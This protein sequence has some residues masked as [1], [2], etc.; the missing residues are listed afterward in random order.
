M[1]KHIPSLHMIANLHRNRAGLEMRI[2]RKIPIAHIDHEVI[3]SESFHGHTLRRTR[4]LFRHPVGRLYHCPT[5][6]G[7]HR[8]S[9]KWITR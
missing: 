1:T 3:P 6:S 4:N 8:H 7:I 9:E 5:C 2:Q